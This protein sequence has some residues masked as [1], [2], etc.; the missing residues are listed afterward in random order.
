MSKKCPSAGIGKISIPQE[1]G[2]SYLG[3]ANLLSKLKRKH[4]GR[5]EDFQD[6]KYCFISRERLQVGKM[7]LS[8][9]QIKSMLKIR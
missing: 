3:Q 7:Y 8:L 4:E 1:G 5:N 6:D 2:F 9:L